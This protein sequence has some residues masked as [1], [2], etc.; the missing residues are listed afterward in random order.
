MNIYISHSS[1]YDYEHD[2][3]EPIKQS[4]LATQHAFFLPHES[5]NIDV[6]A[7][8]QFKQTDLLVA[9]VSLP[10]TGQ[11]IELGQASMSDVPIVCFYKTGSKPSGALRFV[12]DHIIE[13]T[14]T[15]NLLAKLQTVLAE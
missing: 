3:Y 12:T 8:D 1:A 13:Y 14:D 5:E 7:I 2:I 15:A 9:E 4:E 6:D 10:S 11:G